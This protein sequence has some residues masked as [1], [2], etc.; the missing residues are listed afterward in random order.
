[1]AIQ[2]HIRENIPIIE[3]DGKFSSA[4]EAALRLRLDEKIKAG[5][6]CFVFDISRF[7]LLDPTSHNQ[8]KIIL[9]YFRA[10]E[11]ILAIFGIKQT[12]F[13]KLV[14][15]NPPDIAKFETETEA[16]NFIIQTLA[17]KE[18]AKTEKPEKKIKTEALS[19]PACF[20]NE[21]LSS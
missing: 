12:M 20:F 11:V 16:K 2:I 13:S 3:I 17:A 19:A 1:M 9:S 10:R 6:P 5:A 8:I 14:M 4:E 7:E 15:E 21:Y 18:K